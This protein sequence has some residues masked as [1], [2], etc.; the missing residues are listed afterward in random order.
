MFNFSFGEVLLVATVALIVIGPERLPKA[1]QFLGHWIKRIRR[2]IAE[3]QNDIRREMRQEDKEGLEEA[4]SIHHEFV[5]LGREAKSAF[6]SGARGF[7]EEARQ[8]QAG[9]RKGGNSETGKLESKK[10][11]V[12]RGFAQRLE[13][14]EE[15]Q[16]GMDERVRRL[17]DV[18][19]REN[20]PTDKQ[21]IPLGQ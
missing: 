7:S 19:L 17:E 16:A 6:D 3:V 21:S 12:P 8:I 13:S 14:V 18:R 11:S 9:V 5:Q 2:Q 15:K 10:V 1:A 20:N 4:K